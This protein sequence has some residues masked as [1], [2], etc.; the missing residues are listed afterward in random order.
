MSDFE[1]FGKNQESVPQAVDSFSQ[2][3]FILSNILQKIRKLASL[4]LQQFYKMTLSEYRMI[5]QCPCR[6]ESGHVMWKW[7]IK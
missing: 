2:A 1:K 3:A 4:G 7:S 5:M 6:Q